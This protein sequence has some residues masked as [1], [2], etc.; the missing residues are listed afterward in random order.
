MD[1][2][3]GKRGNAAVR[4]PTDQNEALAVFCI[5]SNLSHHLLR[6]PGISRLE[7]RNLWIL[8]ANLQSLDAGLQQNRFGQELIPDLFE[9]G[10]DAAGLRFVAFLW[11]QPRQN[12]DHLNHRHPALARNSP[13]RIG[14]PIHNKPDGDAALS[15]FQQNR[16]GAT[17]QSVG[18]H[19]L[20]RNQRRLNKTWILLQ[21]CFTTKH[22]SLKQHLFHIFFLII[23]V[24]TASHSCYLST[25]NSNTRHH[26]H[27]RRSHRL[28]SPCCVSSNGDG[29]LRSHSHEIV[30]SSSRVQRPAEADQ[31][32]PK[33]RS[34]FG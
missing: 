17:R 29:W 4:R 5:S 20:D 14:N 33:V 30:S 15:R 11:I 16:M 6:H 23:V 3:D 34:T 21:I 31:H 28:P 18:D 1:R 12:L 19:L 8:D 22:W 24:V 9:F 26:R 10:I 27:V 2:T 13:R 32:F 25:F 7:I